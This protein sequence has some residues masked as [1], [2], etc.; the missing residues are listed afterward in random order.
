VYKFY[1]F[2]PNSFSNDF[3]LEWTLYA[4]LLGEF[5]PVNSAKQ[6]GVLRA[7]YTY[8]RYR[9]FRGRNTYENPWMFGQ[10]IFL[11]PPDNKNGL[12]DT[13]GF[14]APSYFAAPRDRPDV[15]FITVIVVEFTGLPVG[16]QKLKV[17]WA[18]LKTALARNNVREADLESDFFCVYEDRNSKFKEGFYFQDN[19]QAGDDITFPA[20]YA[21]IEG[22]DDYELHWF[23]NQLLTVNSLDY[24]PVTAYPIYYTPHGNRPHPPIP[25]S[26]IPQDIPELFQDVLLSDL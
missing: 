26:D 13:L 5:W 19:Y 16:V 4:G 25:K 6:I 3:R 11:A 2:F 8:P 20:Y 1:N 22:T 9:E 10:T 18:F 23:T 12:R 21:P 7:S 14:T 15:E 17:P 24:G